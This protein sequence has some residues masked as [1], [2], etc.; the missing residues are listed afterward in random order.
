MFEERAAGTSP[1][2][3]PDV[4]SA[5]SHRQSERGFTLVE[6]MA[7]IAIVGILSTIAIVGYK[8][9]VDAAKVGEAVHVAQSIRAAEE[10]FRS[11]T[12]TYLDVSTTYHPRNTGFSS[13]K[14][15]W[16]KATDDLPKWKTLGVQ[17]DGPVRFGYKVNAGPAGSAITTTVDMPGGKLPS[18]TQAGPWYV[19]QAKGNPGDRAAGQEVYMIGT[20]LRGE[21][22][23]VND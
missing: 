14:V 4:T 12:M 18:G 9:Y 21:L 3:T 19:I 5:G 10:S 2:F 8:R 6:L 13:A 15:D 7:V 1:A 11:E 22:Q 17:T 16:L 20:S 23:W